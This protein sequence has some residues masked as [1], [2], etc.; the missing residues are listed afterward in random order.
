MT[1]SSA[2]D[3]HRDEDLKENLDD[4]LNEQLNDKK[5]Q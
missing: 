3:S 1:H 4:V 5:A 2:A